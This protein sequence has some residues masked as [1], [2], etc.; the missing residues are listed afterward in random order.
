MLAFGIMIAACILMPAAGI[1]PTLSAIG[2]GV[3][4]A[5]A[6]TATI[7]A[8]VGSG[9]GNMSQDH[10]AASEKMDV[11]IAALKAAGV[12]D[13]EI[14]PEQSSAVASFSSVSNV[15]QKINN[16]TVC[17]NSS[18]QASALERSAIIKLNTTD[19][20][21]IDDVLEAARGAGADAY[22]AGYSLTDSRAAT[23]EA[24]EKAVANARENAAPMA[25]AEGLRLGRVLDIEDYGIPEAMYEIPFT[26]ENSMVEVRSYV[27]VTYELE[28]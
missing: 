4:I 11:V 5:L 24:R 15:C 22:V 10:K 13:E 27:M 18:V 19:R 23:L 14:M 20:A 7:I 9:T 8:S 3:A 1:A 28:I 26:S 6:D 12:K 25:A 16:S 17:D 21:R 2:E